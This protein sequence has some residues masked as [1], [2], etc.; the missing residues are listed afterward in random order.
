MQIKGNRLIRHLKKIRKEYVRHRYKWELGDDCYQCPDHQ[1]SGTSSTVALRLCGRELPSPESSTSSIYAPFADS[2][3]AVPGL[4]SLPLRFLV[5]F[6]GRSHSHK[7][8]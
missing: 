3:S 8:I 6:L 7:G 4:D 2:F 5:L 1:S